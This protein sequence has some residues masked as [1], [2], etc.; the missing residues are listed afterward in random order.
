MSRAT[1]VLRR[2][3]FALLATYIVMSIA[4][5]V[6]ALMPDPN[7]GLVAYGAE[8]PEAAVAAVKEAKNL[9]E[10]LL[11]RYVNWLVDLSTLDWGRSVGSFGNKRAPVTDLL[12]ETIPRTLAYVLPALALSFGLALAIG[13]YA[14]MNPDSRLTSFVSTTGYFGLGLPN[15]F[16]AA[17]VTFGLA[18]EL[19]LQPTYPG[20][21]LGALVGDPLSVW[22]YLLPTLVLTSTLTGGQ[23]R[24]VRA[25]SAE[26]LGED[27][28]KLVRSTGAGNLRIVRHVL[29]NAALPLVSLVFADM[30]STLV[31]QVFV[32]EFVFPVRGLGSLALQAI[33]DRNV[34]VII[35]T[36][37]AVAYAGIGANFLQDV[38][39]AWFDPRADFE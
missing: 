32:L 4:F 15:Y 10:P 24:Y 37:M 13:S 38:A 19:G 6:V 25:E 3:G 21:P 14:A 18:V 7:L 23:L 8:D 17:L 20:D 35:G 2:F 12:A 33:R 30:V 28:I 26:I 39:Y 29:S 1:F 36:T 31:V 34:P 9:D 16:L 22:G 11:D 27:F 5:F